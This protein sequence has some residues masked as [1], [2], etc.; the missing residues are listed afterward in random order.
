MT[1]PWSNQYVQDH[2]S[3][4][5]FAGKPVIMEEYGWESAAARL[6]NQ[7][8]VSNATRVQVEGMW[9]KIA[10][11]NKLAGDMFWQF[12]LETGLSTGPSPDVSC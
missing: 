7:G 11:E 5:R 10:V 4:M 9:Q 12:G 1:I 3:A 8:T 2:A 6:Q